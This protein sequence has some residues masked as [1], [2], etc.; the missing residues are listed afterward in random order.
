[1]PHRTR[2]LKCTGCDQQIPH[3]LVA[4]TECFRLTP[5]WLRSAMHAEYQTCKASGSDTSV[6]LQS[7]RLQAIDA[8]KKAKSAAVA[9]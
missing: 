8:I 3:W 9:S 4:C 6:R 7:L 1:M 5:G 2:T